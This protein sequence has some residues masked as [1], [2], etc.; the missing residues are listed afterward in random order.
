MIRTGTPNLVSH[1]ASTSPVGPAPTIKTGVRDASGW[2]SCSAFPTALTLCGLLLASRHLYS[3]C[4]KLL[5]L[6]RGESGLRGKVGNLHRR[7]LDSADSCM[8]TQCGPGGSEM[9]AV[10]PK[11][12]AAE[13]IATE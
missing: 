3:S 9:V 5:A 10:S 6:A 1:K 2:L 8:Y 4:A 13:T 7:P 12:S 11:K